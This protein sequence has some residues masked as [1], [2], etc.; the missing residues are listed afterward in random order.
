MD[1]LETLDSMMVNLLEKFREHQLMIRLFRIALE[2]DPEDDVDFIQ[3]LNLIE[4]DSKQ[5][6]VAVHNLGEVIQS[7]V[8][9]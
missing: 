7:L 5:M 6:A 8:E 9:Q 2:L 3:V 4:A 1:R